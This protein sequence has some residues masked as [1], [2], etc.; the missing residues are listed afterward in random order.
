MQRP[1]INLRNYLRRPDKAFWLDLLKPPPRATDAH[2]MRR[3]RL[4]RYSLGAAFIVTLMYTALSTILLPAGMPIVLA[5][6]I[7]A[8][9][10]G[11]GMWAASLGAHRPARLWLMATLFG[12]LCILVFL[13][14][15]VL[16][17]NIYLVVVA[18]L[19]R[20]LFTSAEPVGR[21]VFAGGPMLLLAFNVAVNPIGFVDLSGFPPA[22]LVAMH[23]FNNVAAAG[24]VLV[25]FDVFDREVLGSE[26][27]LVHERNRS[28]RLLYAVLPRKIADE[29]RDGEKMIANRHP[30]VTVLFAD[31]AGFTPW[32]AQH[33]PEVVVGLLENIFHRFDVRVAALGAEKIKTIGDAYMVISGAPDPRAD[34]AHI[35]AQ[36]ALELL[37]EVRQFREETGI[38]LDLRMGLHTGPVI[39][40]VIGAMRFTYDVW[41]DTVNTASRMESH[42]EPGR[43][44]VSD[45][46]RRLIEDTFHLEPRG[47]VEIKGKGGM[48]T[49]WLLGSA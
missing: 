35:M 44:Q 16:I 3:V 45:D 37:S 18:L 6:I 28:E 21:Y 40:G 15:T 8:S 5:N 47:R 30:L 23:I 11:C 20:I 12:Q 25:L 32:A 13:T 33:E 14:G 41:G 34:H 19:A 49:W 48:D 29:L 46:T 24:C 26:A 43:I 42:G 7:G 31:V 39:A 27:G 17:S 10:Y 4:A 38:P 36:L 9:C 2:D 1:E 22:L